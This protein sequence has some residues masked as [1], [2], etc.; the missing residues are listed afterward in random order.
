MLQPQK[1]VKLN[2]GQA[3]TA[4]TGQTTTPP[5]LPFSSMFQ[6]SQPFVFNPLPSPNSL[7]QSFQPLQLL[8]PL[9]SLQSLHPNPS[10]SSGGLFNNLITHNN[11]VQQAQQLPPVLSPPRVK[12]R[13]DENGKVHY[14]ARENDPNKTYLD[15]S[16]EE[17]KTFKGAG[18]RWGSN[19][20]TDLDTMQNYAFNKK[21]SKYHQYDK[22]QK[23]GFGSEITDPQTLLRLASQETS[24]RLLDRSR[25]DRRQQKLL[26]YDVGHYKSKAT[27]SKMDFLTKKKEVDGFKKSNRDHIPSGESL[28]QRNGGG[29]ETRAYKEGLTIAIPNKTMHKVFSDTFG[30]RQSTQ[31]VL[32]KTKRARKEQDSQFP[33]LAAHRDIETML[34]KTE[35]KKLG[36]HALLDLTKASS[37][38]AQLGGYR[39]LYRQ[40]VKMNAVDGKRGVNPKAHAYD[41]VGSTT[42]DGTIGP[43]TSTKGSGTQG[44]KIS[45][46]FT[47]RL[48][49]TLA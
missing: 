38:Q 37:R 7:L 9:Q 36:K 4:P 8:Q 31:D 17:F 48:K 19:K 42:K 27:D 10:P 35:N 49:K 41:F 14:A 33:A 5:V 12:V 13:I 39:T 25:D 32:D 2:N 46:M 20:K 26:P 3:G 22:T 45:A 29:K 28:N 24:G 43:F 30:G 34:D 40:N 23:G 47:S 44:E 6:S 1:K 11:T 15:M 18:K 16:P 21:T